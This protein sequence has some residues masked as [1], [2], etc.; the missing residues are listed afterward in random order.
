MA[1][2]CQK[3]TLLVI[4]F[5]SFVKAKSPVAV[6]LHG[7]ALSTNDEKRITNSEGRLF[8]RRPLCVNSS[9]SISSITVNQLELK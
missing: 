5:S 9:L 7:F 8:S 1:V 2:F 3:A 6:T 4:R